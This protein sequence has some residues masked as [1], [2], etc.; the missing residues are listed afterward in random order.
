MSSPDQRSPHSTVSA[1]RA[2]RYG[3]APTSPV[4]VP[5]SCGPCSRPISTGCPGLP[6]YTARA[7]ASDRDAAASAVSRTRVRRFDR[8]GRRVDGRHQHRIGRER[9]AASRPARSVALRPSRQ[10]VDADDRGAGR[11]EGFGLV[12]RGAQRDEHVVAAGIR[13]H[14]HR[15]R[16][17]RRAVRLACEGLG[18]TEP[19]ARPGGEHE[20][21]QS[22]RG[23]GHGHDSVARR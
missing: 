5:R 10:S 17:P 3:P 22:G 7:R 11:N 15:E 4:S 19:R 12:G 2:D 6:E 1:A 23:R 21:A 9:D 13:Q 14:P 8:R 20:S 18:A 16:D